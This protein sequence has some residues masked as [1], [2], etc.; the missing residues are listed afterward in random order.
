MVKTKGGGRIRL[1]PGQYLFF[2]SKKT[3]I[4]G[5]RLWALMGCTADSDEC[6]V[7]AD[8][9]SPYFEF[10][11]SPSGSGG[12]DRVGLSAETGTTL[13]FNLSYFSGDENAVTSMACSLPPPECPDELRARNENGKFV[14]CSSGDEDV[15]S[16]LLSQ[17]CI[18]T[19]S[20]RHQIVG[21]EVFDQ[22]YIQHFH[23]P[24]L[25]DNRFKITFYVT[26]FEWIKQ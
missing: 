16:E 10:L 19:Q 22:N 23:I 21:S 4:E 3:Q 14:G 2:P 8:S 9:V 20:P 12:A 17:N 6:E 15:Y 26:G 13:P 5:V 24:S 7:G 25:P 18:V 1:A 11:F